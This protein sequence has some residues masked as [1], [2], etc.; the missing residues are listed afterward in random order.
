MQ[1]VKFTFKESFIV[2][3]LKKFN[4]NVMKKFTLYIFLIFFASNLYSQ[5]SK[6]ITEC[7]V[8]KHWYKFGEP[9]KNGILTKKVYFNEN[10]LPEK[11]QYFNK[12]GSSKDY[13][14]F[15]YTQNNNILKEMSYNFRGK[16]TEFVD[17]EYIDSTKL[18]SEKYYNAAGI[19]IKKT[20]YEYPENSIYWSKRTRYNQS[21]VYSQTIVEEFD[22]EG[23]RLSGKVYGKN[24]TLDF[25]FKIS[26][27]DKF[28]NEKEKTLYTV[29]GDEFSSYTQ[30]YDE[31]NN[32]KLKHYKDEYKI[33][34]LYDE[35]KRLIAETYYDTKTDEPLYILIYIYPKK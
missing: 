17:Y 27:H 15:K 3:I 9:L 18:V 7:T 12:N 29:K 35:N 24:N 33:I 26:G 2:L 34:Y 21:G 5:N 23:R 28:G 32:I 25:T 16:L 11:I 1:S 31:N 13:T 14:I 19:L 30:E 4:S 6:S 22:P 10:S 8:Y 20:S